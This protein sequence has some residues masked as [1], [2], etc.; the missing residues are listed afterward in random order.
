MRT[1]LFAIA[2]FLS[3]CGQR[4]N[5]HSLEASTINSSP[6]DSLPGKKVFLNYCSE[7]HA[8]P[9][10]RM[11]NNYAFDKIF[12]RLPAP[13][14][15]YFIR[16]TQNSKQLRDNGDEYALKLASEYPIDYEHSFNDS[17][18]NTEFEE[19]IVYIRLGPQ[20]RK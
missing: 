20:A 10:K 15:E 2:V 7:C 11:S 4:T 5:D 3:A 16:F 17:L 1:P 9:D 19:L 8:P 12:E 13:P 6:L 14:E 18:S